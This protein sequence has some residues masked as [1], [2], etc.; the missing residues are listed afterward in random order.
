VTTSAA[1]IGCPTVLAYGTDDFWIEG[2]GVEA[3]SRSIPNTR[4]EELAGFGHYP[5]EE[6]PR[7]A[8]RL[9]DWLVWLQ[10]AGR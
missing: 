2:A 8:D 10:S 4:L 5:M 3:L 1:G 7:F 9:H 6:D